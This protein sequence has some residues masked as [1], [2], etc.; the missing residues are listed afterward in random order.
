[1]A[2]TKPIRIIEAVVNKVIE[3]NHPCVDKT[4]E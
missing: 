1:M 2:I 4:G 3:G